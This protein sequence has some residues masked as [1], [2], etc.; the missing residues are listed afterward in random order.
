MKTILD[1]HLPVFSGTCEYCNGVFM[2]EPED[3]EYNSQFN[4]GT[5]GAFMEIRCST[6]GCKS[7]VILKKVIHPKYLYKDYK[8]V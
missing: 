7:T 3:P 1:G 4:K 6:K 8:Q 5:A 2:V